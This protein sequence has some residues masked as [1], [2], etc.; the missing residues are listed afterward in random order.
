MLLAC[1]LRSL[2]CPSR[3]VALRAEFPYSMAR[4]RLALAASIFACLFLS[5]LLS[6]IDPRR[7]APPAAAAAAA[8][9]LRAPEGVRL[10]SSS[11]FLGIGRGCGKMKLRR[12]YCLARKIHYS[13]EYVIPHS[14]PCERCS[15]A[16]IQMDRHNPSQFRLDARLY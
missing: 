11:M 15:C 5:G 12:F 8:P 6:E 4:C 10:G 14:R 16:R 9:N 1:F 13:Y 2:S 7:L 3:V